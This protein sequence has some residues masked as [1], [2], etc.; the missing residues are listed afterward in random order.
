MSAEEQAKR[1]NVQVKDGFVQAAKEII[2]RDGVEAVSVRKVAQAAGYSY[3]TIYHYFSDINALLFAAKESMVNDVA[4]HFSTDETFAIQTLDDLKRANRLYATYY[5][6]RPNLYHFF[7]AYRLE[8][9]MIPHY[10][11]RFEERWVSTYREFVKRG[12]L[13][14]Q[15]VISAAK[16]M[17]FMLHGL[18]ALYFSNNGLTRESFFQ[19]IDA[20][21]EFIFRNRR[22]T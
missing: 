4:A 16:A 19:E 13:Q 2:L 14:E 12:L 17:I 21:T 11:Q 22:G 20:A 15:E 7:Y 1:K 10:N 8:S 5:L 9:T 6:D 3:A 18:L